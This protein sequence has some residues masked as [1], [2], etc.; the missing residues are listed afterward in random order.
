VVNNVPVKSINDVL[1]INNDL[2][3]IADRLWGSQG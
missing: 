3:K 2:G 1:V